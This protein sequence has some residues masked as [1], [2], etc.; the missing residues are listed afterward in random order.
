MREKTIAV[1]PFE[2][3]SEKKVQEHFADGIAEEI[4]S[5]L[6]RIPVLRV[7]ARTSSFRFRGKGDD[8]RSIGTQLGA[9]FVG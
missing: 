4:L 9:G 2:D 1:L 3:L 8:L 5:L 7:I 6:G